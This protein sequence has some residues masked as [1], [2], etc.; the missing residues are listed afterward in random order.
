MGILV[1]NHI[2]GHHEHFPPKYILVALNE[3]GA[4]AKDHLDA[5][6]VCSDLNFVGGNLRAN[7]IEPG[8]DDDKSVTG[9]TEPSCHMFMFVSCKRENHQITSACLSIVFFNSQR[10]LGLVRALN[11]YWGHYIGAGLHLANILPGHKEVNNPT[12][13]P[14]NW[15]KNQRNN[16]NQPMRKVMLYDSGVFKKQLIGK[17]NTFSQM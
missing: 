1:L 10:S 15:W 14:Q 3:D 12:E 8:G 6:G 2:G 11:W 5:F 4:G 17:S 16:V 9:S 13:T 7:M